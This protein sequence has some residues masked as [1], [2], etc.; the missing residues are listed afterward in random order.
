M[1]FLSTDYRTQIDPDEQKRKQQQQAKASQPKDKR[2]NLQKVGGFL[3]SAGRL[4]FEN[5][6]KGLNTAKAGAGGLYGLGKIT[7]ASVF[8]SDKDYEDTIKGVD[9]T[10][11]KDLAGGKTYFKDRNEAQNASG[12]DIARKSV[13]SGVATATEVLPFLRGA[14]VAGAAAKGGE[15]LSKADKA[16]K[17]ALLLTEGAGYGAASEA[18]ES[19][20]EKGKIN[21]ADTA[22]A[23]L[24]GSASAAG[25]A[26]VGKGLSK[27]IKRKGAD[28]LLPTKIPVTQIDDATQGVIGKGIP[29]TTPTAKPVIS[30]PVSDT[31]FRIRFKSGADEAAKLPQMAKTFGETGSKDSVSI[32]VR[33]I[34][35]ASSIKQI[36][37]VVRKLVPDLTNKENR[38]LASKLKD[39]TN[40]NSVKELINGASQNTQ[41]NPTP[42]APATTISFPDNATPAQR[43][44][45]AL[46]DGGDSIEIPVTKSGYQA[47]P[48]TTNIDTRVTGVDDAK[49]LVALAKTDN[50]TISASVA[51]PKRAQA[52]LV[53]KP[54]TIAET[55]DDA[56]T[57]V[58][59]GAQSIFHQLNDQLSEFSGTYKAPKE[60][61]KYLDNSKAV[62]SKGR[63]NDWLDRYED[64]LGVLGRRLGKVGTDIGYKLAEGAKV[65]ADIQSTLLPTAKRAMDNLA[66]LAKS[67]SGKA[68]VQARIYQ[69]L[70][71]RDNAANILHGAKEKAL[72][73]DAVSVLDWV[74]D[75]RIR[76][77]KAVIGENYSPRAA[78]RDALEAPERM[79]ESARSAFGRDVSSSFS[80]ERSKKIPDAEINRR[81]I[82]L[83]PQYISSQSKEFAYEGAIDYMKKELPNVDPA[84]LTDTKSVRRGTE[85]LQTLVKQVLDPK[86]TTKAEQFQNKLIANTYRNQL[87]FSLKYAVTNLTQKFSTMANTTKQ[88]RKL[89]GQMDKA[90][91]DALRKGLVSGDTTVSSEAFQNA[92]NT[93]GGADGKV[94]AF[95]RRFD[96][97]A[98][99][100]KLNVNNSFDTG[101]A[102][103]VVDSQEYKAAIKAGL[104]P[105]DAAK[106]A[107]QDEKVRDLAVR[108]GNVVMN[109]TQFGANFIL[110]P[111]F[112]RESDT[113][114]GLSDK[115]YKQY[116]R[117]PFGMIQQAT[118]ILKNNDARALD[119]L[120]RGNPAETNLVDYRK[121]AEALSSGVDDIIK[122]VKAGEIKDV[123]LEVAQ[124]YKKSL[125]K[126]T[127][128]LNKEMKKVSLVRGRKTAG[129]F[130]KMWAAASAIQFLFDGGNFKEG[131]EQTEAQQKALRYG[132]PISVPTRDQNPLVGSFTPSSPLRP[133]GNFDK[134]KL[135]NFV[136][137]VGLAYSRG[138]EIN[139]FI[140]ALT[141]DSEQ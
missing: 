20:S 25:G 124:G 59:K 135:L 86:M 45:A 43:A 85:Y 65:R 47:P 12:A 49:A 55:V 22:K 92:D 10:L 69:A 116:Q 87:G 99:T 103:A 7:A 41:A 82:E 121:S 8:G 60:L 62:V 105:K 114:F 98:K 93:L 35:N 31:D 137:G 51:A 71:D 113:F 140:G 63:D 37:P 109:D 4:L 52:A 74:K 131:D 130:A 19:L 5:T 48:L 111:E 33:N 96:P 54:S 44:S 39:T 75:E 40:E 119:I 117:F 57:D 123:S 120:R 30:A 32:V 90:D 23:A 136:P 128:E 11:N 64:T 50:P 21:A 112:F 76:R 77:G 2:S 29:Q 42:I 141:G 67:D 83:L 89:A 73:D 13:G 133:N 26:L 79:F 68:D 28:Q 107:L 15:V 108:R 78:V 106:Q 88:A 132:A 84:F 94:D 129:S 134:G 139:K 101:V 16:K 102:Q 14:Q 125:E 6:E 38:E 70:E 58:G 72:F 61:E 17:A 53:G 80:K 91:I 27:V 95:F 110:K 66:K 1:G 115:W 100:E 3:G 56:S 36:Q 118:T 122:G 138:K 97:G 9:E 34:A 18:G 127:K 81:I 46:V 104:R 24:I 126:A